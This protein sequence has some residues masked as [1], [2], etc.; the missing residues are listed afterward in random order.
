MA[1]TEIIQ[2]SAAIFQ[3]LE[4]LKNYRLPVQV[5]LLNGTFEGMTHV[6]GIHKRRGMVYFRSEFIQSLATAIGGKKEWQSRFSFFGKDN[7]QYVFR[8]IGWKVDSDGIWHRFPEIIERRQRRK[9]FRLELPHQTNL[10]LV[11]GA[12]QYKMTAIDV[13]IGGIFGELTD[14]DGPTHEEPPWNVG[15]RVE[16]L[17][18]ETDYDGK[19]T[20][21]SIQAGIL[22]RLD[23]E[24]ANNKYAYAF[25]FV[26]MTKPVETALV[27]LVYDLQRKILKERIR[28]NA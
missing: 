12:G 7:I 28:I 20:R 1:E 6:N 27:E 21:I 15:D 5:V 11:V 3:L 17:V 26:E 19:S 25:E 13:S 9:F 8:T 16:D 4:E 22:R 10:F 24:S 2:D 18:L 23:A 14:F